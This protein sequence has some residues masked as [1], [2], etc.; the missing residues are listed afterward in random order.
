MTLPF[1]NKHLSIEDRIHDLVSRLTLE[2]KVSQMLHYAPA[3]ERFHIPPY[4]WWNECLHGVARAGVATVFPQAIGLA[5]TFDGPLV[6]Q[7][8]SVISDEA[9]AKHHEALRQGDHSIY[10]GLTFWSPNVNIFRDPR[11]GRGHETYGEDPCL[12]G[13]LGVAFIQGIQGDDATYLKA[14]ACAKHFAVHSGPEKNRHAFNAT[15]SKKDLYETYLPAFEACVKEGQVEAIMGAYNRTNKEPCCGSTFLLQDILRDDWGFLGHVVSD[16]GAISDFHLYHGVTNTPQESAAMAVKAGSDLNCGSTYASLLSA[17][18]QGLIDEATINTAVHRLFSTRFRLG[19][20]DSPG[21][22]PYGTIPY[23]VN[24]SQEH[25]DLAIDVAR[26]SMV[27]LK[28]KKILPL[29]KDRLNAIAVIGPNA[30]DPLALL[31]NYHGTPS[32]WCTPLGGI[33]DAVSEGTRVYYAKGC[34]LW[35]MPNS[36][37]TTDLLAE[38]VSAA[39]YADVTILCVGLNALIEGEQGDANNSDAAGDKKNLNLPGLQQK[40]MEKVIATGTPTIVVVLAGSALD[41]RYANI[42]A[43]AIIQGWYPGPE[44]GRALA[45][46][47][48]GASDFSGRL[49]VTFYQSTDDLPDFTDYHMKGRTYRYLEKDPLYP[50]GYGLSYNTYT[51][52]HMT[53]STENITIEDTLTLTVDVTNEGIYHGREV[54]QLYIK[55]H[56]DHLHLPH[57]SLVDIKVIDLKPTATQTIYFNIKPEQRM[58]INDDGQSILPS[59]DYRIYVGGSQPDDV[60]E[61]LTGKGVLSQVIHNKPQ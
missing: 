44:G 4:N 10:K 57:W 52:N 55:A 12:T 46:L 1:M 13:K 2:E 19:Q 24:D 39:T 7:V 45:D 27:L 33:R 37:G 29:K 51:Y 26:R 30:D 32:T 28:N 40:L 36:H 25:H 6:K 53:C 54:V 43:D 48:F 50:F 23:K 18:E 9:R 17:V 22:V 20:F 42:H 56:D 11:W 16:C 58:V 3:I 59:G 31:G 14:A 35:Q 47:I 41:L 38:A 8:A 21:D 60:S 34:D 61:S 15:V 5:A 49:P